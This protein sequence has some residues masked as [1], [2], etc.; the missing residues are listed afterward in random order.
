MS[1]PFPGKWIFELEGFKIITIQEAR[2]AGL[3]PLMETDS[4]CCH[5]ITCELFWP[6]PLSALL[7][8]RA[9]LS[10]LYISLELHKNQKVTV[11]WFS[12]TTFW[13]N[14]GPF[15]QSSRWN[16]C[17]VHSYPRNIS[18]YIRCES[19]DKEERRGKYRWREEGRLKKGVESI[20]W[21]KEMRI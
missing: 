4:D 15:F 6:S 21:K 12:I 19:E 1:S 10:Q 13:T 8:F 3:L 2:A 18:H 14:Q 20:E 11:V 7:R 16:V 5:P 9:L 17:W